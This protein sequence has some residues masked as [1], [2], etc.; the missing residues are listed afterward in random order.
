M[1][2]KHISGWG[3]IS[4]GDPQLQHLWLKSEEEIMDFVSHPFSPF[5]LTSVMTNGD[6]NHLVVTGCEKA[7]IDI[8]KNN[9]VTQTFTWLGHK[10]SEEEVKEFLKEEEE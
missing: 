6:E 7:S 10:A 9:E 2:T 8:D 4:E 1:G 5:L 3:K